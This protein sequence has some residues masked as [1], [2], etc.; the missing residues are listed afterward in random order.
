[1]Q[2]ERWGKKFINKC[3]WKEYSEELVVR[4]EF[5]LDMDWVKSWNKELYR[6]NKGKKGA[7]YQFPESLIQLQAVWGQWLDY[8]G[9]EGITRKVYEYNL[10]PKYNDFSTIY[11]RVIQLEIDFVLPSEGTISV[12]TDGSGMKMNNGGTYRERKYGK[13]RRKSIKVVITADP[14]KK[15]LLDCEVSIEGEGNS[16]PDIAISHLR[17]LLMRDLKVDLFLGD[18]ALDK[19]TLFDLLAEHK[20]KS[21][22]KITNLTTKDDPNSTNRNK[23]V[24]V[25]I[26]KGYKKWAKNRKYGLRWNTEGIF[27]SVKR[28]FGENVRSM[29]VEYI[30]KEVKRKF[31]VY[32]NIKDY[33]KA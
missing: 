33:A 6:M 30:L 22:I 9:L 27:S 1:M 16:E 32:E 19:K 20:I 10:I 18:G 15:K 24:D 17:K 12:S 29:K 23:E 8:R 4:G 31:W 3:N 13:I 2:K 25:F 5:F 7:P 14:V 11:R 28:K 26:K 21:G